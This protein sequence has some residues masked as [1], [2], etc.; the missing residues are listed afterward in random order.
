[1][2]TNRPPGFRT[3]GP[4]RAGP[5]IVQF[6]VYED[7]ESLKSSGRRMNSLLTCFIGRAAADITC[8]ELRGSAYRPR[9]DNGSGDSPRPPFLTEFVNHIGKLALVEVVY[10][11]FGGA[12]RLR[13]HPHIERPFRLKTESARRSVKLQAAYSKVG[14]QTIETPGALLVATSANDAC[15]SVI[16]GQSSPPVQL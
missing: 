12:L 3:A 15:S 10:H 8:S 11:L 4:L 6:T 1:M 9:P 13:I 2:T 14:Q 5:Q 7:S 16:C